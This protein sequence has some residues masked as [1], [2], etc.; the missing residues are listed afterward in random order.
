M[1]DQESARGSGLPLRVYIVEDSTLFRDRLVESIETPG[2]VRVIGHADSEHA[3]LHALCASEWDVLI[4]D[5]QLRRGSGLGVLKS[6]RQAGRAPHTKVIVLTNHDYYL[7][8]LKTTEFGAEHFFDKVRQF[9]RVM[10][11]LE[12]MVAEL[13]TSQRE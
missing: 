3:A 2:S 1:V 11:V 9:P 6:L 4:L 5:L 10:E 12:R 8:R 7:Y 13:Q